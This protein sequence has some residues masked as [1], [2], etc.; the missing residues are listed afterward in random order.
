MRPSRF[1]SLAL[2]LLPVLAHAGD[3]AVVMLDGKNA[4]NLEDILLGNVGAVDWK[5][6]D[7]SLSIELR[8][9][10]C[11]EYAA[12][13]GVHHCSHQ[14][15]KPKT[16]IQLIKKLFGKHDPTPEELIAK[17][18]EKK[19]FTVDTTYAGYLAR[20]LI[21]MG[22]PTVTEDFVTTVRAEKIKCWSTT[23][24]TVE[25]VIPLAWKNRKD[26][27]C[28]VTIDLDSRSP[29]VPVMTIW[30][31]KEGIRDSDYIK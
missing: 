13:P 3:P 20:G 16:L 28:E 5:P 14:V 1:V 9:V 30:W 23:D 15:E 4:M 2:L 27:K 25:Q 19:E 18:F 26:A 21:K 7:K 24:L 29:Y 6:G 11:V 31:T 8:D 12:E 22:S 17:G 10:V